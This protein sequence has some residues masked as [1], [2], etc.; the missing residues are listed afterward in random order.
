M[1]AIDPP[2]FLTNDQAAEYLGIKP[3]TLML[4]RMTKRYPIAYTKVGRCVRYRA[5]D[6]DAWLAS[7]THGAELATA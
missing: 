2:K 7:R 1:S 3:Q 5:R 4:W 6:L